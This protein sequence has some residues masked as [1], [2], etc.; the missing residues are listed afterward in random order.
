MNF[1]LASTKNR[2]EAALRGEDNKAEFTEGDI[3]EKRWHSLP[4]KV[5][6]IHRSF[7]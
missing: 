5:P 2:D 1:E 3:L 6:K 4:N 7:K